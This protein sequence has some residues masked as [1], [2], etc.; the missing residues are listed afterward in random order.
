MVFG[1]KPVTDT[2]KKHS[3]ALLVLYGAIKNVDEYLI[4]QNN[5]IDARVYILQ[6]YEMVKQW[7][8]TYKIAQCK[9]EAHHLKT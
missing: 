7:V 2:H 1:K 9:D 6:N 8:A 4:D 3:V 5:D